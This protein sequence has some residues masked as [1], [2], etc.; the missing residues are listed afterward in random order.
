[1][2][3]RLL[4]VGFDKVIVKVSSVSFIASSTIYNSR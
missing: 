4:F 3:S 1:M 2:V